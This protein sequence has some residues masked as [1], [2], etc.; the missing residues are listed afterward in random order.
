MEKLIKKYTLQ[1]HVPSDQ[2]LVDMLPNKDVT[3]DTMIVTKLISSKGT[4]FLGDWEYAY[5]HDPPA[6]EA[7]RL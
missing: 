4:K 1:D 6:L 3:L 7:E 5:Q 2:E